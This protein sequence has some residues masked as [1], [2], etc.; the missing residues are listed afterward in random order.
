MAEGHSELKSLNKMTDTDEVKNIEEY[1]I[2]EERN[3]P[4]T[5][6]QLKE[7]YIKILTEYG[8]KVKENEQ[9][10]RRIEELIKDLDYLKRENAALIDDYNNL[11]KMLEGKIIIVD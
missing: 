2:S 7:E 4:K 11:K 6:E 5:Y 8:L 3:I 10:K 9:L 1:L